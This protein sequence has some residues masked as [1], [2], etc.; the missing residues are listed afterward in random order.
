MFLG[1]LALALTLIPP[2]G[3]GLSIAFC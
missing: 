1:K 2:A 3:V